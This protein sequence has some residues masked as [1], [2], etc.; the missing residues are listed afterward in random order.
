[1][2]LVELA[3]LIIGAAEY[4]TGHEIEGLLWFILSFLA[5]IIEEIRIS[6]RAK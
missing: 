4:F 3:L 2:V 6:R 5:I 1:M